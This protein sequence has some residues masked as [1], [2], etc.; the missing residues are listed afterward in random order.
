[1]LKVTEEK[2]CYLATRPSQTKKQN[3]QKRSGRKVVVVVVVV[4]GGVPTDK[5][6][7]RKCRPHVSQSVRSDAG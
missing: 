6:G 1:M 2:K 3:K 7:G 4:G 5:G